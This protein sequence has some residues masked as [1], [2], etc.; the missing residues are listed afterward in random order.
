MAVGAAA[1]AVDDRQ[2]DVA[3]RRISFQERGAGNGGE[4][5]IVETKIIKT[6]N[7]LHNSQIHFRSAKGCRI[8]LCVVWH[9]EFQK[10]S[11]ATSSI[12]PAALLSFFQ[13]LP[14]PP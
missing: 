8:N 9:Y 13:L 12:R 4:G 5:G 14:P 10:G 3:G 2:T 6:L 11:K 7:E 1:G